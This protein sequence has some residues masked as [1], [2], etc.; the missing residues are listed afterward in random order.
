[1]NLKNIEHYFQVHVS[2]TS[3]KKSQSVCNQFTYN[4]EYN[5][6]LYKN[7]V[8]GKG[9]KIYYQD[10]VKYIGYFIYNIDTLLGEYIWYMVTHIPEYECKYKGKFLN[11][12]PHGKGTYTHDNSDIYIGYLDNDMFH[13]YGEYT[14]SGGQIY[15]GEFRCDKFQGFGIF[16]DP[17]AIEGHKYI[18]HFVNDKRDGHGKILS[19]HGTILQEGLYKNDRYVCCACPICRTH[20]SYINV[21]NNN[22]HDDVDVCPI[23]LNSIDV[24]N[25]EYIITNCNHI[26]CKIC[27]DTLI[28]TRINQ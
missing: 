4:V 21:Y 17:I 16:T 15:K 20:L 11:Y 6:I 12:L 5:D 2:D 7:H 28:N 10:N 8:I 9:T 18:G 27:I 26:F 13:W 22:I 24:I 25:N 23:C 19:I 3:C 14:W 1:M